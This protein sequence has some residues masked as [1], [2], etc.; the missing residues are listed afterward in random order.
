MVKT[1]KSYHYFFI[2]M[3]FAPIWLEKNKK[4]FSKPLLNKIILKYEDHMV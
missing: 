4:N 2:I 1:T 3:T